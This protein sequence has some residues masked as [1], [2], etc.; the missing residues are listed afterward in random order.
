MKVRYYKLYFSQKITSFVNELSA[1]L[2]ND[3]LAFTSTVFS[4]NKTFP[5]FMIFGYANGTDLEIDISK[6]FIDNEV[7][8]NINNLVRDLLEP[9][10]IDN[11]IF[12]YIK[13]NKI[14]K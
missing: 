12:G 3:Y 13:E 8:S 2:Y 11:N 7:Y 1:Y 9:L 10:V 14:I 6:Y 4:N 5:I